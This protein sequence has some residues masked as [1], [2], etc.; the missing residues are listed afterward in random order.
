MGIFDE[1]GTKIKDFSI[2]SLPISTDLEE[3]DYMIIL[4]KDQKSLFSLPGTQFAGPRTFARIDSETFEIENFKIPE[5]DW[6]FG[7]KVSMNGRVLMQE[8][9]YLKDLNNQILALSPSTSAFYRFDIESDSLSFHSFVHKS[10]PTAT[11]VQL[12]AQ[13]ESDEEYREEIRRSFMG[14]NFGPPIWDETRELYFRFSRK[15]KAIDDA[16]QITSSQVFMYIYDPEFNLK[17]EL[18]ITQLSKIPEYPF[19]KDGK[20][21][22][23]V[24][25]ED[26]LGFAVMDFKF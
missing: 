4:S 5:M 11:E 14:F 10:S 25:V 15:G 13:V 12:N 1:S 22:S 17:G 2:S 18:E 19:F 21:W 23:Y 16:F 24:N 26:E 9:M 7:I 3:L 6:I 8:H 20:L